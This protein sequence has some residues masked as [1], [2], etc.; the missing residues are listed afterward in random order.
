MT[1][2]GWG[3]DFDNIE[4]IPF[5]ETREYV[6]AVLKNQEKYEQL[7]AWDAAQQQR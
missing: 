6:T 1:Q 4:D 3:D 5:A 7:Y 2:Y